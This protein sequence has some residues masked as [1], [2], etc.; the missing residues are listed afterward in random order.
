MLF[1]P[2][3]HFTIQTGAPPQEA[4]DRLAAQ[5]RKPTWSALLQRKDGPPYEGTVAETT[6]KIQRVIRYRN[7]FLPVI[8]GAIRPSPLGSE[9]EIAM[10]MQAPVIGF[11][12]VWF[13]VLAAFLSAGA[14]GGSSESAGSG[15]GCAVGLFM[16]AAAYGMMT[17]GFQYEAAKA[18]TF[19]QEVFMG[20]GPA[21]A[22]PEFAG[23]APPAAAPPPQAARPW[24]GGAPEALKYGRDASADEGPAS[25][26]R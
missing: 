15:T 9:I 17:I 10:R 3:D 12:V 6:F 18:R 5:V 20:L 16:I 8:V 23:S 13:G 19:L 1:L 21:P 25:S 4:R 2:Y 7:S 26:Q 11:M 24:V 14:F 22:P